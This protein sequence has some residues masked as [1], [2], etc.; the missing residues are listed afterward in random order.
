MNKGIA[1]IQRG[2]GTGPMKPGNLPL[3]VYG[4][5]TSILMRGA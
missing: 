3:G 4:A 1:L 5:N 2:G